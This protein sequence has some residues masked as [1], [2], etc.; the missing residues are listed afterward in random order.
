ME[1]LC[2]AL[3]NVFKIETIKIIA[4]VYL[5]HFNNVLI[6]KHIVVISETKLNFYLKVTSNLLYDKYILS[7]MSYECVKDVRSVLVGTVPKIK[8]NG[9]YVI[10]INCPK[11]PLRNHLGICP[12]L[13]H[14]RDKWLSSEHKVTPT[15]HWRCQVS[16][17][18]H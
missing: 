7:W 16:P 3:K 10:V 17:K 6:F 18:L 5:V 12:H 1:H 14:L 15:E 11:M 8:R 2:S 9:L 4:Q 13:R